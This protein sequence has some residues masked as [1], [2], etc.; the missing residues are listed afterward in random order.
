MKNK[1]KPVTKNKDFKTTLCNKRADNTANKQA[2]SFIQFDIDLDDIVAIIGKI[3][4]VDNRITE[5]ES[6]CSSDSAFARAGA[7]FKSTKTANEAI[8]HHIYCY[9]TSHRFSDTVLAH[10]DLKEYRPETYSVIMHVVRSH[11]PQFIVTD[12]EKEQHKLYLDKKGIKIDQ[13][14]ELPKPILD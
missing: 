8:R 11:F 4:L 13:W 5:P 9:G 2:T 7:I 12:Q 1:S 10:C 14:I 3:L 6:P